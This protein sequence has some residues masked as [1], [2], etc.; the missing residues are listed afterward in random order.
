MKMKYLFSAASLLLLK[1]MPAQAICPVCIVAVGAGL[2]LSEYLGIDDS[3]AGLWIGGLLV[4]ISVWTINYFE[5]KQWLIKYRN[6]R[7]YAIFLAYYIMVLYPLYT[8]NF[9]GNPFNQLYGLDKLLLGIVVGSLF[10]ALS[11][12]AY[13]IIKQRNGGHAH[14]P[15]E[16]VAIPVS[17]LILLS[18]L[19]Y[20]LTK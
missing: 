4:G 6:W 14:F 3:I 18:A 15:F 2:G 1:A 9:I 10:F 8:Q 12:R 13:E 5:K 16:K 7:D 11:T 17:T 20:F 19:F